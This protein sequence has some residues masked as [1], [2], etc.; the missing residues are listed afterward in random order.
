MLKPMFGFRAKP[1]KFELPLRYYDPEEDEKRRLKIRIKTNRL[2]NRHR[3]QNIRV[4]IYAIGL[5]IVIWIIT[6]L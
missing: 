5:T 6:L 4:M 3:G 2:R 1:K